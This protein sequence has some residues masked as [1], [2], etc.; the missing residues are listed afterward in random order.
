[1]FYRSIYNAV[2][3][4]SFHLKIPFFE[5]T[6]AH[7]SLDYVTEAVNL[8][9]VKVFVEISSLFFIPLQIFPFLIHHILNPV[10]N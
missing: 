8:A 2:K 9:G 3:Y 4:F 10:T 6:A 1:M 7:L 5:H